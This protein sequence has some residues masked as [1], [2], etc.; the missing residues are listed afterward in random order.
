MRHKFIN[1]IKLN[2]AC[3]FYYVISFLYFFVPEKLSNKMIS[4]I[5][6]FSPRKVYYYV[7]YFLLRTFNI[8]FP[9]IVVVVVKKNSFAGKDYPIN[10]IK[11]L[12]SLK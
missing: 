2:D 5:F 8:I 10:G 4:S 11:S 3:P 6:F 12:F 9:Q 7:N 1:Q